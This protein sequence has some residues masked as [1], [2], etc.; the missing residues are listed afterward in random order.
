MTSVIDSFACFATPPM[1]ALN[2]TKYG[3]A[4]LEF[5]ATSFTALPIANMFSF[6]ERSLSPNIS[7]SLPI[8]LIASCPKSSPRAT[9]IILAASTNSR[10]SFFIVI[11]RRPAS[12]ASSFKRS[13]AVRVSIFLNSSFK[14]ATC[15]LVMPVYL[16]T[17]LSASCICANSS[18]HLRAVKVIPVNEAI[19]LAPMAPYLLNPSVNFDKENL[20]DSAVPFSSFILWLT[21]SSC[22]LY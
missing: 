9:S 17:W 5:C 1:R 16:R 6:M 2:S 19:T 8:F 13:R 15:S 20:V 12:P 3:S 18:T 4:A 10:T 11:P 22:A 14:S 21:S 7:A